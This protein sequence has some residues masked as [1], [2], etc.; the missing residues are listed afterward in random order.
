MIIEINSKRKT[1]KDLIKKKKFWDLNKAIGSCKMNKMI[2]KD[3]REISK[4][5]KKD[6]LKI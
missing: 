5:N 1:E 2:E 6:R 4:K 3:I